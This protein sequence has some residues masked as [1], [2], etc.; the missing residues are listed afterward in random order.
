MTFPWNKSDLATGAAVKTTIRRLSPPFAPMPDP[1]TTKLVVENCKTGGKKALAVAALHLENLHAQHHHN[2]ADQEYKLRAP[3]K[4]LEVTPDGRR[5]RAVDGFECIVHRIDHGC[6]R[7]GVP[8]HDL[9][10]LG[11]ADR[12]SLGDKRGQRDAQENDCENAQH[13]PPRFCRANIVSNR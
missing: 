7:L 4:A 3:G 11:I 12:S 1:T 9:Q 2:D 5:G 10:P 8:S 13:G 6:S